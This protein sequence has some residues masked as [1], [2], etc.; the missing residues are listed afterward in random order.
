MIG[1]DFPAIKR[2]W[3]LKGSLLGRRTETTIAE[4]I[5]KKTGF[6]VLKDKN[7]MEADGQAHLKKDKKVDLIEIISKDTEILQK[8]GLID[9]SLFLIEVDRQHKLIINNEKGMASLVYNTLKEQFEM[10][11]IKA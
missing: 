10:K 6:K 5:T 3:D 1:Q 11:L 8:F 9:Y 4:K 2:C 7:I